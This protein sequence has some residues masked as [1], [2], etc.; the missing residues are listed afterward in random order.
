MKKLELLLNTITRFM[1]V[2]ILVIAVTSLGIYLVYAQDDDPDTISGSSF[3]ADIT[4]DQFKER[5]LKRFEAKRALPEARRKAAERRAQNGTSGAMGMPQQGISPMPGGTPNY[6]G[7]EPN[8]AYS[9]QLTKFV[10]S[11]PGLGYANR[12]NLGQYIPVAVPDQTTYSGA[13]YYE[14]GI[15]DHSEQMHSGLSP[16]KTRGYYQINSADPNVTAKHY[17]G[18]LIIAK[19]DVPVRLKFVNNVATSTAGSLFLPVDTT[20]MGAGMGPMGGMEMYTQNRAELHLHGIF[21]PWISD[22]T[23][24]QWIT[25]A[26]EVTSY[27]RGVSMFNV[28]DMPDP[29]NG[30]QTYYYP[31]QQSGRLMFYHDHSFGI[32]RLNVYAGE[33]SGYIIRD[34]VLDDTDAPGSMV[35]R[36]VIPADEIPL[37]IQDKTFVDATTITATDPTWNWGATPGSP[38]TG[39][40]WFPHVYMPN[41]DQNSPTGMNDLGRWDYG[42][43]VWPPTP[44]Q[45]PVLPDTSMVMEAFMDTPVVNGTA[46]P[47]VTLQPKAYRFR[48]LNA[49]ND[50]FLNLQLYYSDTGNGISATATATV[51][52]G[53]VTGINVT[54]GGSGYTS[55]P[56]IYIYGGGGTGAT[57]SATIAGGAVTGITVNTPGTGYA[58]APT[59]LVGSTKEVKMVPADGATYN[60]PY[61]AYTVKNDGRDG[62]VPDPTRA[63]PKM[64]VIGNEG[65]ILPKPVTLNA[66]PNPISYDHAPKTMTLGNVD[67]Y[68]LYLGPAERADVI[69]DFSAVPAGAA[70]ILYNDAPA[71]LP[72][73]D[74]RYDYYTG[75]GDE[76]ATGGSTPTVPELGPN[77]RTIMQIRITGTASAPFNFT[78]LD[79]ELPA[80][81][82]V[83]QPAPHVP[84]PDYPGVYSATAETYAHIMDTS[85]TF[86]P[87]GASAPITVSLQ[88]KA[89]GEDFEEEYGRMNA[90]LGTDWWII[91]ADGGQGF[92][93][94]YLDPPT[95]VLP[96]NE[97][98]IWRIAHYGV[99]TH[100]IHW[101]LVNVQ[102]IN[103]VDWAGVI[104]APDP[105]ELGW[106][107]TVKVNPLEVIIVAV[108]SSKPTLPFA[109]PDSV[110]PLDPTSP[111]GAIIGTNPW[112]YTGV[113]IINQIV[114]FGWEYV[115]HCHI[116][117]HEEMDMMRPLVMKVPGGGPFEPSAPVMLNAVANGPNEVALNWTYNSNNDPMCISIIQRTNTGPMAYTTVG[118]IAGSVT[119]FTDNTVGPDTTYTYCVYAYNNGGLSLPSNT[120]SATTGAVTTPSA[121]TGVIAA[122]GSGQATVSFAA[123]AQTGGTPILLY[124][125]TSNPSGITAT[126]ISS[127]IIVT[128][129]TNGASYN[130]TVKATNLL[131]TGQVSGVSNT[132]TIG[133]VAT[134]AADR[135]S[136]SKCGLLGPEPFILL[137]LLMLLK[138]KK[139]NIRG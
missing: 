69:V 33:A 78:A 130:F 99:D 60:G 119:S 108:K 68:T 55:A 120:A 36:G 121:P 72:A 30:A 70:L 87:T 53:A 116:L 8:W 19:R 129:L 49:C 124:T 93:F 84:Q 123:P 15:T 122:S 20:V 37:I 98:Q 10:D 35:S 29:G 43:L 71:P 88:S 39:D 111:I 113:P 12:N 56:T 89:I 76:T 138:R 9:P 100:V 22:G 103:R 110:R 92:G 101:H 27:P 63:G 46:Y 42:P 26:G 50:R 41:Q 24:H 57:A 109:I 125:V 91:V 107:E 2:F 65:G 58:T 40:L 105:T 47:Y 61:G 67:G 48:V 6:F 1:L 132:V 74:P 66:P 25:P 73:G 90:R 134:V 21:A 7:P 77:T 104:K 102:V 51:A 115:W 85:L 17:L 52:S 82:L 81:Y 44:V 137:G 14:I 16:T 38:I 86:I 131:G 54:N 96:E 28:P 118:R 64:V 59:I 128:G 23:P 75:N 126:G 133:A 83:T 32:T 11:L 139:K 80:A 94:A 106:K 45:D 136:N 3:Q 127:P 13:D 34:P 4:L 114:N 31:N 95:E 5:A 79:T 62:G 117:G 97:V 112:P 135:K 18:P